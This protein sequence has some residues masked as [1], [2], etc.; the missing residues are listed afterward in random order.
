MLNII[1]PHFQQ[2]SKN[3]SW[4]RYKTG[5]NKHIFLVLKYCYDE[6]HTHAQNRHTK[7]KKKP[8]KIPCS[9]LKGADL[10]NK[11]HNSLRFDIWEKEN[12]SILPMN[13]Q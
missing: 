10:F 11:K 8:T 5:R 13:A 3:Q 9:Q 2:S 1:F 12:E 6:C 7:G 4:Y